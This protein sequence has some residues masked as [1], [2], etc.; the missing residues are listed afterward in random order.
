MERSDA[1]LQH[2]HK[3]APYFPQAGRGAGRCALFLTG[4]IRSDIWS[5]V[6]FRADEHSGHVR[7]LKAKLAQR[8]DADGLVTEAATEEQARWFYHL[9]RCRCTI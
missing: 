1:R 5:T 9:G 6:G 3:Y 7:D 2:G 4:K 8:L